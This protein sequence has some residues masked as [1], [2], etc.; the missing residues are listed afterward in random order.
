[1]YLKGYVSLERLAVQSKK[2]EQIPSA[3]AFL[4]WMAYRDHGGALVEERRMLV[5]E[6][7]R[8]DRERALFQSNLRHR[9]ELAKRLRELDGRIGSAPK[10]P[11]PF[12]DGLR[13]GL[14]R[15]RLLGLAAAV[16]AT[17][18]AA[19]AAGLPAS[20]TEPTRSLCLMVKYVDRVGTDIQRSIEP[21]EPLD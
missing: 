14:K 12:L 5:E 13:S 7:D 4:I 9:D 10:E 21:S 1:M 18:G 20:E 16:V 6:I 11:S 17:G 2:P 3:L 15:K 19:A 8:L